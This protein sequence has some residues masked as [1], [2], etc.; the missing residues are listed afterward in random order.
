MSS[1]LTWPGAAPCEPIGFGRQAGSFKSN[2]HKSERSAGAGQN[3]PA[4]EEVGASTEAEAAAEIGSRRE[5]LTSQLK[6][7][8]FSAAIDA[9]A[10]KRASERASR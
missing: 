4:R 7:L 6:L 8:S 9:F 1:S 5:A 3:R 2:N 10:S